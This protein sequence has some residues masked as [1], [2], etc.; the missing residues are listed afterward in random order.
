[1]EEIKINSTKWGKQIAVID[2]EYYNLVNKH[3]W[4][5]KRGDNTFYAVTHSKDLN[6]KRITL[7]MHRLVLGIIDSNIKV[8]HADGNGLNNR[9]YNLRKCTNAQNLANSKSRKGSFSKYKGVYWAKD[10]KK[11]M[12]EITKD[13]KKYK[14]GAFETEEEAASAYNMKALDLHREFANLNVI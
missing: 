9:E 5:L 7:Y 11:W 14:I 2:D 13:Y 1:M 12:A 8:D 3:K 6:G 4:H 10:R